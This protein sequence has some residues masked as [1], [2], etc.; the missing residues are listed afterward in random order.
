MQNIQQKFKDFILNDIFWFDKSE[1]NF[2]I[3][4]I[5][6]QKEELIRERI[7]EI[8][9]NIEEQLSD[10]MAI[11]FKRIKKEILQYVPPINAKEIRTL[12]DLK[13]AAEEYGGEDR[14][15]LLSELDAV[16]STQKY[17][18]VKVYEYLYQF[19]SLY[20]EKGDFGYTPRS[21]RT[22]SVPYAYEEYLNDPVRKN[23]CETAQSVDYRGEETLFTWKTKD[24][25]YIKSKKLMNSMEVKLEY[26]GGLYTI[27]LNVVEKDENIKDDKKIKQYRLVTIKKDGNVIN[28]SFN[29][30]DHATPKHTTYLLL[31]SVIEENI[32]DLDYDAIFS[33]GDLRDYFES[34]PF[35]DKKTS[36]SLFNSSQRILKQRF[37]EFME[38]DSLRKYLIHKDKNIFKSELK[39]KED[40]TQLKS[41]ASKLKIRKKDYASKI[42]TRTEAKALLGLERKERFE[43]ENAKDLE[44][45]YAKDP[46]LDFFYRLDRGVNLF[47]A[48]VDSDYFIH[49]NLKRFLS[50]ELDKFIKNYIFADTDAILRMDET[51]RTITKFAR[52]FK[53]QANVFIE[54]LSSI[55]EFQKYLWEKRKM[56]KS[57]HYIISSDK[58]GDVGL[59]ERVLKNREQ[60]KEWEE[61]GILKK[62]ENPN[63]IELQSHSYPIDTRHFD[64][65]FKYRVLSLFENIE[66]ELSGLLIKS[67]NYQ[68]LRFLEPKYTDKKGNGKIKC[69]YIDPPYNTGSDGFVYK[70][71]FKHASWLSMMNDRLNEARKLMREDGVIFTSIDDNQLYTLKQI[72]DQ[73]FKDENFIGT[74]VWQSTQKNDPKNIAINHEYIVSYLKNNEVNKKNRWRTPHPL[75]KDMLD[76]FEK[77][78]KKYPSNKEKLLNEWRNIIKQKYTELSHYKYIDE[79][80]VYFAAD[81]SDPQKKGPKH[82]FVIHPITG[83]VCKPPAGGYSPRAD[84]M[85]RRLENNEIHFG[86][87]HETVVCQKKYLDTAEDRLNSVYYED[88]RRASNLLKELFNKNVFNNPKSEKMISRIIRFTTKKDENI[89]D[90]FGGSG[91]T[92]HAVIDLNKK[93][94]QQIKFFIVEMNDYFETIIL[95]RIK[96]VSYSSVWKKGI[97]LDK[98]GYSGIFQY[99]EL[100][101]YDDIVDNLEVVDGVDYSD[102]DFGYI[103]E[104]DKNRINFRMQKELDDP[105]DENARFDI[106]TSLLFH[107]GLDLVRVRLDSDVLEAY[108]KNKNGEECAVL[109]GSGKA[110]IERKV[111]EIRGGKELKIY[112]N[113]PIAG[114]E[115]ILAET[116]KGK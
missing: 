103:Y 5:F 46:L 81:I 4:K 52:V 21:F 41:K 96:K 80:G 113:Q 27:R 91:S 25:Y 56:V 12:E 13:R 73:V 64:A 20:Y 74:I 115:R 101:Q 9:R 68:A 53:E 90:F 32:S 71:N 94:G 15:R 69:V 22:Y 54:L 112:T 99:I 98:D 79:K 28:L 33:D 97:A 44:R 34:L 37:K 88:G 77:L 6:R 31:L 89:L 95:P 116:F 106:F 82:D 29:I 2:G 10:S 59:L 51:S 111:E 92:A 30:S 104:P 102:I 83:K 26:K 100:E 8:V 107:E 19:F 65:G 3:Y 45:L 66:E 85:R 109:L 86:K 39:G 58:I 40:E 35:K 76:D 7:D 57:S 50:V 93:N 63:L 16:S 105:L 42:Y 23:A 72:K 38:D 78:K 108:A 17:N 87:T 110:A 43:F 60:L 75:V 61:L 47:Y 55:E 49:K 48:G 36:A 24:S 62:N 14:E 11:E 114:T 67:E 18:S 84:E 70:D 1:L